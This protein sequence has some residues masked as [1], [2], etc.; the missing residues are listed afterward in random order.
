M[1]TAATGR[2]LLV[3]H[4]ES[5]GNATRTFT[6]NTEI[7]LTDVGRAQARR[8]AEVISEQFTPVLVVA[9]PYSRARETG[10]IIA[11]S[12]RLEVHLEA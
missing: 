5:E 8:A 7:P 1:T 12:L 11:T 4:G 10:E 6:P 2:I 3:R 9:S